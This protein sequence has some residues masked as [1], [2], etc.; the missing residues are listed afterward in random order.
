MPDEYIDKLLA[1]CAAHRSATEQQYDLA[2]I[3]R[4]LRN[5]ERQQIRRIITPNAAQPKIRKLWAAFCILSMYTGPFRLQKER[6]Q[7]EARFRRLTKRQHSGPLL[8][9]TQDTQ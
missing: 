2:A 4:A 8:L 6:A 9:P 1:H 7:I 5:I 3:K